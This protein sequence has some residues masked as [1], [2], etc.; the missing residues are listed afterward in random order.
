MIRPALRRPILFASGILAI[1]AGAAAMHAT[2]WSPLDAFLEHGHTPASEQAAIIPN[3]HPDGLSADARY[4]RDGSFN[5]D[6]VGPGTHFG[7]SSGLWLDRGSSNALGWGSD[8]ALGAFS[9]G[10]MGPSGSAGNLWRLMGL[11]RQKSANTTASA[12]THSTT[13]HQPTATT[14]APH[15]P[16]SPHTGGTSSHPGSSAPAP[17]VTTPVILIGNNST[18]VNGLIGGGS[19]GGTGTFAPGGSTPGG[20]T[21]LGGGL[22]A[23]PEPAAMLLLGTGLLGL[24]AIIRRRRA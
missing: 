12:T 21:G 9:S 22:S 10:G 4:A 5:P 23:T 7:S 2:S 17:T 13:P 6:A 15:T 20:G 3:L 24:A 16:S 1:A 8:H 11:V 19:T 14:P 18:P